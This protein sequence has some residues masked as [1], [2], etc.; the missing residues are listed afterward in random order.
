MGAG[1]HALAH[2]H[3]HARSTLNTLTPSLLTSMA[4][5]T[6]TPTQ[7]RQRT[8]F[9]S[10]FMSSFSAVL[11][12]TPCCAS[13]RRRREIW[14]LRLR[15]GVVPSNTKTGRTRW[16]SSLDGKRKEENAGPSQK[17]GKVEKKKKK[18]KGGREVETQR[19]GSDTFKR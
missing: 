2:P 4:T 13:L 5:P 19:K 7:Y 6:R 16:N 14:V 9:F 10:W 18:R 3:R 12:M 11:R 8:C 15:A 1:S 17:K